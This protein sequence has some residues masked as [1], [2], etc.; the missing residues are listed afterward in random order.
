MAVALGRSASIEAIAC[1]SVDKRHGCEG[2]SHPCAPC[3]VHGRSP[4]HYSLHDAR[5]V[6]GHGSHDNAAH[7]LRHTSDPAQSRP[8]VHRHCIRGNACANALRGPEVRVDISVNGLH[9]RAQPGS[10]PVGGRS[11][12]AGGRCQCRCAHRSQARRPAPI[13]LHRRQSRELELRW[14]LQPGQLANVSWGAS[15]QRMCS[16]N[17]L[18]LFKGDRVRAMTFSHF[19]CGASSAVRLLSP[20][21]QLEPWSMTKYPRSPIPWP[22]VSLLAATNIKP[23]SWWPLRGPVRGCLASH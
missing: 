21:S 4:C 23:V 5:R 3:H 16:D 7:T 17:S 2:F 20:A 1:R 6:R 13:R 22:D 10:Q 12:A 19:L 18:A 11:P 14:S 8:A 9:P 15:F